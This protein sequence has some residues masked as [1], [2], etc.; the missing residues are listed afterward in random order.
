[1]KTIK[2]SRNMLFLTLIGIFLVPLSSFSMKE[3][4]KQITKEITV[5]PTTKINFVNKLGPVNVKTW[6][7]NR[8]KVVT[9]LIVDGKDEEVQKIIAYISNIDFSKSEG[10]VMFDTKFYQLYSQIFGSIKIVLKNGSVLRGISKIKLS[11]TLMVPEGNPLSITNK[12]EDITLSDFSGDITL[13]LYESDLQAGNLSGRS[14][15]KMKYSKSSFASLGDLDLYMYE[16]KATIERTGD[17]N[18]QSKYSELT[19][20]EAGELSLDC[21]EDKIT[22]Q[23]HGDVKAKAK[24]TTLNLSDFNTGM[25]KIYETHLS[26]GNCEE[27]TIDGKY[28]KMQIKSSKNV[29]FTQSY[30]NKFSSSFIGELTANS[31]YGVYEIFHLDK[32]LNLIASYEDDVDVQRIGN[33]FTG[34]RVNSKYTNLT[35]TFESGT[36]YKI[37]ANLKYTDL[38]FPESRFREIRFHKDGSEF[39]YQGI[40][41]GADEAACP[42]LKLTMYEGNVDL[43]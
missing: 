5:T 22:I 25:F 14:A 4:E 17:L 2:S 7:E 20:P 11:Y 15:I 26:A 33:Q 28:C 9:N 12:Y 39:Q 13:E 31:K 21:Y 40:I 1:M 43:K 35:F 6:N 32:S 29:T 41:K 3:T 10:E 18:L 36:Q 27:I 38:N 23:K 16:S 19:L 30:E 34:V 37:D 8:V 24:Y 42:V